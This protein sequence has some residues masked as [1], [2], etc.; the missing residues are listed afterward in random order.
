MLKQMHSPKV[1][2]RKTVERAWRSAFGV[3]GVAS[4]KILKIAEKSVETRQAADRM[5]AAYSRRGDLGRALDAAAGK[6][7]EDSLCRT[8]NA[9]YFLNASRRAANAAVWMLVPDASED[10]GRTPAMCERAC[11]VALELG[12]DR[13]ALRSFAQLFE[14]GNGTV[15]FYGN[16][17]QWDGLDRALETASSLLATAEGRKAMA[18]IARIADAMEG[19]T[20]EGT[21]SSIC[22]YAISMDGRHDELLMKIA[23]I[24][25]HVVP[26]HERLAGR[27]W[28]KITR[29]TEDVLEYRGIY[30]DF[31][32]PKAHLEDYALLARKLAVGRREFQKAIRS[33][34][35]EYRKKWDEFG[36]NNASG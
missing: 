13:A 3:N 34:A 7:D 22:R 12:G 28:K 25:S 4:E 14:N 17:K 30:V 10:V 8:C 21:I 20:K 16:G 23:V 32:T 24:A 1:Y 36:K 26:W 35:G 33:V 9:L 18:H 2:G 29:A 31:D 6:S 11:S 19:T 15:T 27:Y 5:V